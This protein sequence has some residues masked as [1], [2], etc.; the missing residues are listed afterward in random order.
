MEYPYFY[1]MSL[2]AINWTYKQKVLW[3]EIIYIVLVIVVIPFFVGIQ[4]WD[5]LSYT[6]SLIVVNVFQLPSI[7]LFYRVFLPRT[8]LKRKYGT[9]ILLFIPYLMVYELNAR[10]ASIAAIHLPFIPTGYQNLLISGHPETFGSGYFF[11][12]TFGYTFLL[13][14]TASAI[15]IIKELFKQQQKVYEIAYDKVKLELSHLKSQ[16]QPHFFFNTLNNLYTL[17][18]QQSPT[19]PVMIANLSEI[20]RYVIYESEQEKVGLDKEINFMS[21]YI[22]L[23]RIRHNN[24]DVIDFVVQGDPNLHQIE[25]LLFLPLIENCFKHALQKNVKDNDVRIVLAVDE[26]EL[27]FQTT[28]KIDLSATK[29]P[30]Y[31]GGIGLTNVNKRLALLYPDRHTL[32]IDENNDTFEVTLTIKFNKE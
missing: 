3:S 9:F 1:Q 11:N 10:L 13:L 14:L 21:K 25:P 7:L 19:A 24:P 32:T 30:E 23:E 16:V 28:N 5:E 4:I 15:A 26:E 20:M 22:A 2:K 17:S 29:D 6:F 27:T 8:I 18:I 12:Q 31:T